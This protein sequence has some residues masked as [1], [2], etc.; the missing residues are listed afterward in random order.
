MEVDDYASFH[1][2]FKRSNILIYQGI[3]FFKSLEGRHSKILTDDF[4]ISEHERTK[5]ASNRRVLQAVAS[6]LEKM[7]N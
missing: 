4:A 5:A 6:H 7:Y 2:H 3:V 1:A